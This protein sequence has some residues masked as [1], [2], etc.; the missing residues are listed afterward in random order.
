MQLWICWADVATFEIKQFCVP[1]SKVTKKKK[2]KK[3]TAE[4]QE[5][6]DVK[7]LPDEIVPSNY[8]PGLWLT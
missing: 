3:S 7:K 4:S 1:D 8:R 5:A 6:E 2:K